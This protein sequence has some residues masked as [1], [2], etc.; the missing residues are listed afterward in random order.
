MKFAITIDDKSYAIDS[1]SIVEIIPLVQ[2][3]AANQEN[4]AIAGEMNYHGN[5]LPVI[6]LCMLLSNRTHQKKFSTR[7]LIVQLETR[8]AGLIAERLTDLTPAEEKES[9]NLD[10]NL[11]VAQC[12]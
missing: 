10:L 1:S 5:I 3:H 2:L 8:M 12:L 6:D 4:S 7:I 11:L 9:C